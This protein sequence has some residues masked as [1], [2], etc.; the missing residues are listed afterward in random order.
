M[1]RWLTAPLADANA[2]RDRL[3]SVDALAGSA[4]DLFRPIKE[5]ISKL[6]DVQ[7]AITGI[8]YRKCSVSE[9]FKALRYVCLFIA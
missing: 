4:A 3:A 1:R 5:R 6:P 7:R 9:C 8:F 2:I